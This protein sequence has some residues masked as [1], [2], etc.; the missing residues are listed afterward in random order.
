MIQDTINI[1]M[2]CNIFFFN[3]AWEADQMSQ[4]GIMIYDVNS[5][6]QKTVTHS[7]IKVLH[8]STS[9]DV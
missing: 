2:I 9:P 1:H 5:N 6:S 7:T 8:H 4:G 3:L